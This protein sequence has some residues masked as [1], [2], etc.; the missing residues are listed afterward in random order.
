MHEVAQAIPKPRAR[1]KELERHRLIRQRGERGLIELRFKSFFRSTRHQAEGRT[2]A[3]WIRGICCFDADIVCPW[4]TAADAYPL[5]QAYQT[6]VSGAQCNRQLRV[7]IIELDRLPACSCHRLEPCLDRL[8]QA[9]ANRRRDKRAAIEEEKIRIDTLPAGLLPQQGLKTLPERRQM[10]RDRRIL[11]IR[12]SQ[13]AQPC[14]ALRRHFVQRNPWEESVEDKLLHFL[15]C[16]RA[17]EHPPDELSAR[18]HHRDI[19]AGSALWLAL[20]AGGHSL[21]QSFFRPPTLVH[22]LMPALRIEL[23][24][25]S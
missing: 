4:A 2:T 24:G 10:A 3:L 20:G 11:H 7:G 1:R 23:A 18:S 13:L 16:E 8:L 25:L 12:Q 14:A 5:A 19:H 15:T 22:Q 21:Q 6:I 9:S 17:F